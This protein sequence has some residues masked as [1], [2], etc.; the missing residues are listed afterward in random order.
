MKRKIILAMIAFLGF[1]MLLIFLLEVISMRE[2][3]ELFIEV[4]IASFRFTFRYVC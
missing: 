2:F 4:F 1:A 3:G